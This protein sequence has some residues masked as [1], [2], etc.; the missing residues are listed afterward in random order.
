MDVSGLYTTLVE[1][2]CLLTGHF[3]VSLVCVRFGFFTPLLR[4]E[5]SG[6]VALVGH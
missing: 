4:C 3:Y 2:H 1:G 5:G 6:G